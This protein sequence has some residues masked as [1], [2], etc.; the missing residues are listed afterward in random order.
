MIEEIIN[1][2]YLTWVQVVAQKWELI[3]FFFNLMSFYS[4][5][6][7]SNIKLI[8]NKKKRLFGKVIRLHWSQNMYFFSEMV[9]W[10]EFKISSS[11]LLCIQQGEWAGGGFV[12]VAVGV[13]DMWQVKGETQHMTVNK[14]HVTPDTWHL[15]SGSL[16]I[17]IGAIFRTR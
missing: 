14:W 16:F 8:K 3:A 4:Q 1:C 5:L 13:S 10:V 15:R 11:I 6:Q 9:F 17:I 2:R 12:A 7:K